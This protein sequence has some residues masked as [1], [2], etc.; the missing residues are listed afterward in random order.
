MTFKGEVRSAASLRDKL[1]SGYKK[2]D[3]KLEIQ[4]EEL[5]V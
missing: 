3:E 5:Q 1:Y 4:K 2:I